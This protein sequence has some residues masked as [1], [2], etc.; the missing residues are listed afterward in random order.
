M[1]E[2]EY[3]KNYHYY[4]SK[5]TI[6]LIYV[7]IKT[8][9]FSQSI[10]VWISKIFIVSSIIYHVST[11]FMKVTNSCFFLCLCF[12]K[13]YPQC[14]KDSKHSLDEEVLMLLNYL[15]PKSDWIPEI[16]VHKLGGLS[17]LS[18]HVALSPTWD[19]YQGK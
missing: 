5:K 17:I 12:S 3:E 4:V 11:F 13:I 8:F 1:W 7:L 6:L 9:P 2:R 15:P 14:V 19:S 16:L 10:F 18:Q